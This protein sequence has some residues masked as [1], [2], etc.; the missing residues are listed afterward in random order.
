MSNTAPIA[1]ARAGSPFLPRAGA[2]RTN[3]L[4]FEWSSHLTVWI[5]T[6]VEQE[7]AAI[8]GGASV[9]D[10]SPLSKLEITG[11]DASAFIARLVTRDTSGLDVGR[12]YYAPW[13]D[14]QGKLVG[15]GIVFRPG[16][17]LYRIT[18]GPSL[19]WFEHVAGDLDVTIEDVSTQWGILAL[20]G[21]NSTELL[22]RATG[23]TWDDLRFSRIRETT[24]GGARVEVTR[25]GFTGEVGYEL[26]VGADDAPATWDAL[27][28]AGE[29]LGLQPCGECAIDVARV[30]AGLLL[31]S[32]EYTTA[33]PDRP[34]V[35]DP[36]GDGTASPY[37]MGLGRLVDL[38]GPDFVGREALRAEV[39]A[40]GPDTLL[41]GLELDWRAL[42]ALAE[43]AGR[44]AGVRAEVSW[45]PLALRRD[46]KPAGRATSVTWSP[47]SGRLIAFGSVVRGSTQPGTQVEVLWDA[48]GVQGP[49]PATV[50]ELPFV[51]LRRAS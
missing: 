20:Q 7:L 17:Q 28:A 36:I 38:D 6:S 51:E 32:C 26:W 4:L 16:E 21:P 45:V 10:M 34:A 15:D 41:V 9:N 2:V 43:Q 8:R 31:V 37:A 22:N 35:V 48:D 33:G 11:P 44:P 5:Y 1:N 30:E 47:T 23:E 19:D 24:I 39:A 49:V 46:G 40:G 25:Q 27:A 13:C 50:V 14:E 42:N 12:A 29:G 3:D 18:A